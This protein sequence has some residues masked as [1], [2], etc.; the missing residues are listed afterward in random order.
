MQSIAIPQTTQDFWEGTTEVPCPCG[1]VI[2]WAEAAYV[3][4]S[5]ACDRCLTL[6]RVR[7]RG[8]DRRLV[9]QGVARGHVDDLTDEDEEP[10]RVPAGYF[11][12]TR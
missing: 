2:H 5:R 4:G 3:P 12:S 1:G 11:G 7:D 9:P 10:Y 6:Y 8:A